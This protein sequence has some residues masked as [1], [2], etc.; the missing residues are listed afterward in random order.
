MKK[1]VLLSNSHIDVAWLWREG[2]IKRV[3]QKTF[4][5]ALSLIEKYG[6]TYA[7]SNMIF[8]EW[9]EKEAPGLYEKILRAIHAGNWEVVGGSWVELD[10]N[11]PTGESILRSFI[12][13]KKYAK[14]R[15]GVDI[16]I[17]WLPDT[18]G[19]PITLPKILQA[20]GIKYFL[21]TKLSWNDTTEFP[22]NV[23]RW[24]GD[25][26]SEV[27]AYLTPAPYDANL[28]EISVIN[29]LAKQMKKQGIPYILFLYG[30]GDHGGGP[31]NDDAKIAKKLSESGW[32][33]IGKAIDFFKEIEEKY[34]D[35]IP[36]WNNEL[37]LEFHRGI[38][39]T[40]LRLKD[41]IRKSEIELLNLEV[42][43]GF[44]RMH[45]KEIEF[46]RELEDLWKEVLKRHFHDTLAGTLSADVAEENL[47]QLIKVLSRIRQM[48]KQVLTEL[49]KA[50]GSKE[51]GEN[52][53]VLN[54][55]PWD[56]TIIVEDVKTA[57]PIMAENVPGFGYKVIKPHDGS[58]GTLKLSQR[59]R[60]IIV[61]NKRYA[62]FI[63]KKTGL[64]VQI[65]DKK[66]KQ[67]LLSRPIEIRVYEDDPNLTR[68]SITGIP[69]G[70]F[71]A[72]EIYIY[73]RKKP[74][75]EHPKAVSVEVIELTPVR[76]TVRVLMKYT[77]F[78]RQRIF[79]DV[80]YVLTD[81]DK[82]EIRL[83]IKSK[84]KHKFVKLI[85]PIA[86]AE[87]YAIYGAPYG[88]V[89][90]LD[91]TSTKA[92]EADKAK[93]EVPSVGWVLVPAKWGS[94]LIATD[95]RFG[96]SKN[97]EELQI[98]ILR[99][100]MYPSVLYYEML[101]RLPKWIRRAGTGGSAINEIFYRANKVIWKYFTNH[102]IDQGTLNCRVAIAS[103]DQSKT[104][105]ALRLWKELITPVNTH[106]VTLEPITQQLLRI[107]SDDIYAHLKPS[108]AGQGVTLRLVNYSRDA[109]NISLMG[110]VKEVWESD[111]FENA[112][113][114][115]VCSN[116]KFIL[117]MRG[118]EIK[119]YRLTT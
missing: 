112:K 21:T 24:R 77:S 13:G 23:F 106:Y 70:I 73:D 102:Y 99:T 42:L 11:L 40:Q 105:Y 96:F 90:R 8:Y 113:Q 87:D 98:S 81:E 108:D 107:S 2:E 69:A 118:N 10:C 36:T 45:G 27:L 109:I 57:K 58:N 1:A 119:T 38:Y 25:D 35:K 46:T 18:F 53:L 97:G 115:V 60:L 41:L 116:G 83:K 111:H 76:I 117:S 93:Y 61:E 20:V 48:R 84:C 110:T 85:I 15:L 43:L 6:I 51:S 67:K 12:I 100:P 92:S 79:M 22:Y 32:I 63:D 16:N 68:R 19:F 101:S 59:G 50:M 72:W 9:I 34:I 88:Y 91:P 94:A 31:T 80:D 5:N 114:P 17:C 78:P 33:K 64:I 75:Y 26:G 52:I 66:L 74:V 49:A 4:E 95:N 30:R 39:T 82:I 103:S 28:S 65:F 54:T 104:I 37:Y 62:L 29:A 55:L 3:C 89:E 14:S 71:D 44:L 56:R 86:Q 47:C 7:Q